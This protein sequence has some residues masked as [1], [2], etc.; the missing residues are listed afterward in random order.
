MD[1][2]SLTVM[3]EL[4]TR[5]SFEGIQCMSMYSVVKK[6]EMEREKKKLLALW[7]Q[8]TCTD[9]ELLFSTPD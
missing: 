2:F 1:N 9:L 5:Y 3:Q 8:F 7:F 6:K 4:P